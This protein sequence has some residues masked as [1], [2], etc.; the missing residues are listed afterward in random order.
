MRGMENVKFPVSLTLQILV[1]FI[2]QKVLPH[3]VHINTTENR[4]N[5]P[6][7]FK[8]AVH[9]YDYVQLVTEKWVRRTGGMILNRSNQSKR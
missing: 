3:K 2:G 9:C 6:V 5:A 1:C 8:G 7:L 4:T